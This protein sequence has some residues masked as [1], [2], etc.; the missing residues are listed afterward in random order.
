MN[1]THMSNSPNPINQSP[2]SELL[3]SH[4]QLRAVVRLAGMKLKKRNLGRENLLLLQV[5]R[6]TLQEARVIAK[7]EESRIAL[8]NACSRL[9][10]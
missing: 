4:D 8:E 7:A 2:T 5:M 3:K 1:A 6:R 10:G 9:N